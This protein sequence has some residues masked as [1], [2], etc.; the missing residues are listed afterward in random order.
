MGFKSGRCFVGH[1]TC[2]K[3][4]KCIQTDQ[5]ITQVTGRK[6]QIT[7]KERKT[8]PSWQKVTPFLTASAYKLTVITV[9]CWGE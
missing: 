7:H 2:S 8:P 5:Q 3:H 4:T 9:A 1:V 6:Q